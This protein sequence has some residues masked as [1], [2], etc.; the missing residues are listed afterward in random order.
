MREL[1]KR[2]GIP[3]KLAEDYRTSQI[4]SCDEIN[5]SH[6]SAGDLFKTFNPV[7]KNWLI[8]WSIEKISSV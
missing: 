1:Q 3:D 4:Y 8:C 5:E 7:E 6:D 2:G